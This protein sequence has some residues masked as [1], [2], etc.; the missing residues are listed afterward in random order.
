MDYLS[1]FTSCLHPSLLLLAGNTQGIT[2]LVVL[3]LF[4][5]L[6]SF[7]VSGAEVAF[8][9]LSYKDVN[10]LKTK[11]DAGWKRIVGLLEDPKTLLASL[12]IASTLINIAIII[13][14]NFLID[15]MLDLKASVWIALIKIIIIS[16]FLVLFGKVLPKVWASQNNLRFAYNASYIVEIIHYLFRRIS[17]W[18]VSISDSI[19]NFLGKKASSYSLEELDSAIDI[20]ASTDATEKEKS[21]LKGIVKFGN[22]SVKQVMTTRLDVCGINQNLSFHELIKK[23]AELHY[24]RLPVFKENLDEVTGII[25]TKDVLPHLNEN[26]DFNWHQLLRQPYFVH[27]QKLIEDLLKEFQGKRIHFAVVV[28]EFGGTSGIVTLE[29][30]L[31]EITGDIKDEF[32]DEESGDSKIDDYNYIFEGRTMIN[33]V[34]K[35]MDLPVDTFERIRGDSDSLAGLI[36][37]IAGHF[38]AVNDTISSGDFDFTILELDRN[39]IKKVKITVKPVIK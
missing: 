30:I 32:D 39:R 2:L 4:L 10:M 18:M 37:E 23:A 25:H 5:L 9:S 3:I 19:E 29:D 27:E 36:L 35:V 7:F 33:D 16:F 14:S 8:F 20:T 24:S 22:I 12:L 28:D 11:Q 15:E 31:E 1:D 13:L 38:P 34:C 26:N 21:I 17:V 6:I